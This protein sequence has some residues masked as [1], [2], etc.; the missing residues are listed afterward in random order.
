MKTISLL[1]TASLLLAQS[2]PSPTKEWIE[3]SNRYAH[4]LLDIDKKYHPERASAEG[5]A[6][7]DTKVSVP[8]LGND[9]AERKEVEGALATLKTAARTET[10][11]NVSEDL[12][13]MIK[14]TELSLRSDDYARENLVPVLNPTRVVYQGIESLL[15]TQTA[16]AR[17]PAAVLRLK[18]YVG[19]TPGFRPITELLQ[20]RVEAQMA[21]PNIIFPSRQRV[22]TE[23]SRNAVIVT[24]IGELFKQY[25]LTG[26]EDSY[27]TLQAKLTNY[28]AWMRT[29]V[30]P[31]TRSDFRE[32]PKQY[33][34]ALESYGIDIP[35]AQLAEMAHL[36]FTDIQDQM[37]SVAAK[38]AVEQHLPS[39]DYRDVMRFLK[40]DQVTGEAILPLY[41]GRLKQVEAIIR[42]HRLVTLPTR[43]CIIRLASAAETAQSPA[44]HMT[45]PPFLHNTGQRGSFVLPLN[46]PSS[47]GKNTEKYDDFTYDAAAWTLIAHE[48]RPG[49]ELQFDSMVEH[50][51]SL[52]R[53]H[54]AFNST[55]AEGWG[56]YSESI[57][58]PYMPLEGQLVS[59]DGRLLRAARAFL[60]PE[61]QAGKITPEQALIVLTRD[62]V[63]SHAFAREEVE[64]YTLRAPGQANSYFY[65]YTKL[66]AMRAEAQALLGDKFSALRFHDFLLSQGLLPPDLM[67]KA[68]LEEFVP[69]ER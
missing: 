39:A 28:D 54:F 33:A 40:K 11:K 67:R 12:A 5:L 64:R 41:E 13:I 9:L 8:T 50:G 59:L 43:P 66:I 38:I 65:G 30:L 29:T 4:L 25:R 22:E 19:Q 44:P 31:K 2:E 47:D 36:A 3:K 57:I 62:V 10:D 20:E 23:L 46:M 17:R 51:V 69:R 14:S 42:E 52:A 55:N 27:A 32:P 58:L 49:H 68:V 37:N 26:W 21:K 48:A 56:L 15:D 45:P 63:Y 34:L 53:A 6:E 7:F 18:E 16:D 24:G 60:D 1:L 35:P 61:L